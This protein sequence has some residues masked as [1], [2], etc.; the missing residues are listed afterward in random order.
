MEQ[1]N[2]IIS[3]R[4]L[5]R[6]HLAGWTRHGK[7]VYAKC[8]AE[9]TEQGYPQFDSKRY[10]LMVEHG[11]QMVIGKNGAKPEPVADIVVMARNIRE[12][13]CRATEEAPFHIKRFSS[14]ELAP[15]YPSAE[16]V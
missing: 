2:G 1:S 8:E 13:R 6:L 10:R 4:Q 15:L 7:Q 14:W 3:K 12:A 5:M 11:A 16:N 9:L